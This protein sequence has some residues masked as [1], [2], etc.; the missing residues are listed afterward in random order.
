MLDL[1]ENRY[2]MKV[3]NNILQILL[4]LPKTK[5][6]FLS[7]YAIC[8][9]FYVSVNSKAN[10][11]AIKF[12]VL[13]KNDTAIPS[14]YPLIYDFAFEYDY[15][16]RWKLIDTVFN[17]AY[18]NLN[19][20]EAIDF[21]IKTLE[22]AAEK[23][24]DPKAKIIAKMLRFTFARNFNL[25][26]KEAINKSFNQLMIEAENLSFEEA[27][28]GIM[29]QYAFFLKD[30]FQKD[31]LALYY[32]VKSSN[33]LQQLQP[34]CIPF[35][36]DFLSTT[37]RAFYDYAMFDKAAT[38]GK[39]ALQYEMS[40][41]F[42]LFNYNLV[43][44]AY[45]KLNQPDSALHYF[46]LT[47]N[48]L[49]TF[50]NNYY[51]AWYGII[52]GNMAQAYA[53]KENYKAAISLYKSSIEKTYHDSIWDNTCG[54]AINLTTIF[55]QQNKIAEATKLLPLAIATTQAVGSIKD[56]FE[57]HQMLS[58]YYKQSGNYKMAL[59]HT[60]TASLWADS[61]AKRSGKNI[62]V[63]A[64]LNL[65]TEKRKTSDKE[66]ETALQAQK[67]F[68]IIAL[69]IVLVVAV[70]AFMLVMRYRLILKI[71][72]QEFELK[73]QK[74]Q[75]DLALEKERAMQEKLVATLKLQ[76]FTNIIIEKNK[77]I[78]FLE[79]ANNDENNI[80][81]I[82]QLQSNAILTEE[83][84]ND[85]KLLFEKVHQGF[86]FKLKE[87]I[88]SLSPAETRYVALLKLKM[89][90]KEMAAILGISSHAVRTIGYRLKSKL[91]L[92]ENENLDVLIENI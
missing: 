8:I 20:K 32:L 42:K 61:V 13:A 9:L 85:F 62:E 3:Q 26:S 4:S 82:Q 23:F 51:I 6:S 71:K 38:Y 35:Q 54:F 76:E 89:N 57:L 39:R 83:Q 48:H 14:T 12:P 77:Q 53:R 19:T 66:L 16:L 25:I 67:T 17:Y 87:K 47:I 5:G 78:E 11:R 15:P 64:A 74:V 22:V 44:M 36:G 49:N 70:F 79:A 50:S 10:A 41:S 1:L 29:N 60:D 92:P 43:G 69:M 30:M 91:N 7:L 84:W 18:Y 81:I 63:Q 46:N 88:P 86:F 80:S 24:N 68:R 28:C 21:R 37:A 40:K 75:Q 31:A 58:A 56:K 45:L 55:L 65:E 72:E 27:K 2:L 59:L 73:Q 33:L 90:N 34:N 52:D